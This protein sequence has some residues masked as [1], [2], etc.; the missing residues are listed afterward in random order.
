MYHIVQILGKAWAAVWV[1][2]EVTKSSQFNH[3]TIIDSANHIFVFTP[4]SFCYSITPKPVP[5][6]QIFARYAFPKVKSPY[7]ASTLRPIGSGFL[8]LAARGIEDPARITLARSAS[9]TPYG[10]RFWMR[11]P[12]RIYY[13]VR[14]LRRTR[15]VESGL[16]RKSNSVVRVEQDFREANTMS[17]GWKLENVREYQL[18]FQLRRRE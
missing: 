17:H 9:S 18:S 11:R 4:Y 5:S 8:D 12:P 15:D 3:A 16:W 1:A 7:S 6:P 2:T 14:Q 10:W 13:V